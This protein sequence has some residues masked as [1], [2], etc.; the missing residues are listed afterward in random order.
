M[1]NRTFP[2]KAA[3]LDWVRKQIA[4]DAVWALR[5]LKAIHTRQTASERAHAATQEDNGVGFTGVD[6][7]FFS[8]LAER[9]RRWEHTPAHE[10]TYAAPLSPNQMACVH[11][12]MPKYA[13]QLIALYADTFDDKYPIVRA[14]R[15]VAA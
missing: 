10:R 4:T 2:S 12:R 8:S 13:A 6:A 5:A 14:K 7:Q 3:R 1:A 11:K 15:G 9:V